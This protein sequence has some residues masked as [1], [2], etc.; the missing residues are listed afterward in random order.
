[1]KENKKYPEKYQEE[2]VV[3]EPAT[4]YGMD[5]A[6]M[7]KKIIERVMIMEDSQLKEMIRLSNELEQKSWILPHTQKELEE[8]INKG[9]EDIEAG[10][11]VSHED[12]LKYYMK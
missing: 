12:V 9:I 11:I 6:A 2:E 5:T 8:A 10:R 7:R 3:R 1:M 4:S